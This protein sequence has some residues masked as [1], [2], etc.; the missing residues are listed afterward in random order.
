M[1]KIDNRAYYDAVAPTYEL[2][3]HSGYHA[4][5]D[6]EE[7]RCLGGILRGASVLEV[8]CGT[9][10]ILNRLRSAGCRSAVGVDISRGMLSVAQERGHLVVQGSALALP[11]ADESFDVVV[12]FKVLAHIRGVGEAIQ[13]MTRVLKPGGYLAMDF[14]N[15]YSVRWL[16]KWIKG[17][18][19]VANNIS[20]DDVYTRYDSLR[21]ILTYLPPSLEVIRVHGLRVLLPAAVLMRAPVLRNY[22]GAVER[23]LS[24]TP[25]RV[26]GGFLVVI[27]RRK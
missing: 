17:P 15:R 9:G 13:E 25:L 3:R 7:V 11:F 10:L 14:Y 4:F 20:E 6:E 24:A 21:N 16:V 5:L 8:G 23:F 12:C 18:T 27:A 19:R 26:F 22:F 2:E 1:A